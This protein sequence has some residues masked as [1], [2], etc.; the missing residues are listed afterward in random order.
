MLTIDDLLKA[1]KNYQICEEDLHGSID[2][3]YGNSSHETKN[4]EEAKDNMQCLLD[5]YILER[6]KL[7]LKNETNE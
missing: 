3:P 7:Y 4:I 5:Q 6:I 2:N 1:V